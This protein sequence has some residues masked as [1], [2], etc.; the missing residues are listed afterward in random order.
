[1]PLFDQQK[2]MKELVFCARQLRDRLWA[3]PHRPRYHFLP[4]EGHFNDANGALWWK[5]R[6]LEGT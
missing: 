2:D 1:M 5:G 3:D 6:Y 4:P